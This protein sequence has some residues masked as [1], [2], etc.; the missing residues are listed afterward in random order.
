MAAIPIRK[1]TLFSVQIAPLIRAIANTIS[2]I[3]IGNRYKPA[4]KG[5]SSSTTCNHC[6]ANNKTDAIANI[7]INAAIVP[8]EMISF[9]SLTSNIDQNLINYV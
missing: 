8:A 2:P 9:K 5:E 7:V 4:L 6:E 3:A 1:V